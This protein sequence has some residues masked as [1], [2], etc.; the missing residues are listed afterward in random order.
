MNISIVQAMIDAIDKPA[1]FINQN[2]IIEAVNA[3]YR[4]TYPV[5]I[6]L[7]YST[8]Y[9]VSHRNNKPCDQC[10]EQCPMQQSKTTGR[11]ASV[12]HIHSTSE[13][14]SYCDILMRPIF[15]GNGD[16]LGYLEILDKLA[17]AS[18]RPAAGKMIGE[19]EA[20]KTMLNKINRAANSD[21]AVL[22]H[23][24]TGTGK[25][26]VSQALHSSSSRADKP[27]VVIECTGL[28]DSLLESELFGYEK[29]AFTGATSN[30]K[31]LVEAAEGGTL[32]FDEVGD[33]PLAM[34][35]K[36][37]RLFETQ[38]YR[39]VGSVVSKKANFRLVCA[40]HKNLKKMVERGEFR[41]DLYYRIA[42]FPISLPSL[43]ERQS[44]I[45]LI[46]THF[47]AQSQEKKRF[48]KKTLEKLSSYTFPGNIR[49]LRNI[50]EQAILL[51][52]ETVIYESDLPDLDD[53]FTG[54][55]LNPVANSN[56]KY[57]RKADVKGLVNPENKIM[58]LEEAEHAYLA[59]V[60]D[61]FKGDIN[62]LADQLGVSTRTL[63]RKLNKA[64]IKAGINEH[65]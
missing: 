22:L 34:Q 42:G 11:A 14:Q 57:V 50:V 16:L 30:K 59:E 45:A 12:V 63:Y 52:D 65:N 51:A 56:G 47:L 9:Q 10:G 46:A 31:G 41:R 15:D 33:I 2:Y 36:L 1:I 55:D 19:S 29:G 38:T 32:F 25:E 43:R 8:C 35:V 49:E 4:D 21:I 60:Y 13:G 23:G 5:N 26:L 53:D 39:P 61:T 40:S 28:S 6:K 7:G 37:L 18:N 64:G 24:E 44:D 54:E 27:F 62:Q 20:F 48:S 17:F 58:T 3:P